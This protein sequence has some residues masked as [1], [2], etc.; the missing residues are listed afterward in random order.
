LGFAFVG[1]LILLGTLVEAYLGSFGFHQDHY[2]FPIEK[3]GVLTPL[4][5][6][7]TVFFGAFWALVLLLLY[8]SYFLLKRAFRRPTLPTDERPT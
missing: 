8:L 1:S 3:Y 6:Q 4:R 5:W 7:D 2:L